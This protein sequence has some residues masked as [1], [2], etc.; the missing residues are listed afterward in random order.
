[1]RIERAK[2]KN[3]TQD[4]ALKKQK[5]RVDQIKI[6]HAGEAGVEQ[7]RKVMESKKGHQR[8]EITWQ[9][10]EGWGGDWDKII[11]ETEKSERRVTP[12]R[13]GSE[14]SCLNE[15]DYKMTENVLE[16]PKRCSEGKDFITSNFQDVSRSQSTSRNTY[17]KLWAHKEGQRNDRSPKRIKVKIGSLSCGDTVRFLESEKVRVIGEIQAEHE[18]ILGS[19]RDTTLSMET[20]DKK[21]KEIEDTKEMA[22]HVVHDGKEAKGLQ[23]DEEKSGKPMEPE[24]RG[25]GETQEQ[26]AEA[27]AP[28]M[29]EKQSTER[30]ETCSQELRSRPM[31]EG[32]I[33]P[34][35]GKEPKNAPENTV[36]KIIEKADKELKNAHENTVQKMIEKTDKELKDAHE[37]TVQKIIEKA[38]K[39]LKDAHE[40]TVQKIIEKADKE[41]KD[42]HENTIQK[43]KQKAHNE[44]RVADENT[45]QHEAKVKRVTGQEDKLAGVVT[46]HVPASRPQ[47]DT[48]GPKQASARPIFSTLKK[49]ERWP[50]KNSTESKG[51]TT[52]LLF[53]PP[54]SADSTSYKS[55]QGGQWANR[56]ENCSVGNTKGDNWRAAKQGEGEEEENELQKRALF[57]LEA[58]RRIEESYNKRR[59]REK[60]D[61][62]GPKRPTEMPVHHRG[63][64]EN[65]HYAGVH[66]TQNHQRG[67]LPK[68]GRGSLNALLAP[69]FEDEIQRQFH[70]SDQNSPTN[71]D[72][73]KQVLQFRRMKIA[74]L[75]AVEEQIAAAK[76]RA[77]NRAQL[78]ATPKKIDK[79]RVLEQEPGR[80]A[81]EIGLDDFKAKKDRLA[82]KQAQE[83]ISTSKPSS[84]YKAP[85][86][87][88]K[89]IKELNEKARAEEKLEGER[90]KR[91]KIKDEEKRATSRKVVPDCA[92][93]ELYSRPSKDDRRER[94][95]QRFEFNSRFKSPLAR[96]QKVNSYTELPHPRFSPS[97]INSRFKSPMASPPRATKS[98]ALEH[99]AN[100]EKEL[101]T[102]QRSNRLSKERSSERRVSIQEDT[103]KNTGKTETPDLNS[104]SRE[105]VLMKANHLCDKE[106]M[107]K[108][109]PKYQSPGKMLSNEAIPDHYNSVEE[110]CTC[111]VKHKKEMKEKNGL[112]IMN[113]KSKQTA[114]GARRR[115]NCHSL[116]WLG[117]LYN[118][119]T[120]LS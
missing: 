41:L 14:H 23:S 21:S 31:P 89:R 103:T 18:K 37:N 22:R 19:A 87:P 43:I 112:T 116:N 53:H 99:F 39:E 52:T 105:K 93:I 80:K 10:T 61:N 28:E 35:A 25:R 77:K 34:K 98:N 68:K 16:R 57:H 72:A 90:R 36:Q 59:N 79:A 13:P 26:R 74:R 84:N 32:K 75:R 33:I 9:E 66:G 70:Y 96:S 106:Q 119:I 83:R 88:V 29:N 120:S 1:M 12:V 60:S 42:A 108:S 67:K 69:V 17:V 86:Q 47:A 49:N 101:R 95:D 50:P 55:C 109:P 8:D 46:G 113:D 64:W 5:V 58:L 3:A 111:V 118:A 20:R 81:K 30:D 40:N 110:G 115:E 82:T 56:F 85:E 44:L 76:A 91:A 65:T 100:W 117:K 27:S 7:Q 6:K 24:E 2:K 63:C 45:F 51:R 114:K 92:S 94:S 97:G 62:V 38:D 54:S 4:D 107:N 73:D 102:A 15:E 11:T 104:R 71:S 48:K 78:K